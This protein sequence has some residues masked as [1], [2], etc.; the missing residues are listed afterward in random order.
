MRRMCRISQ[1][2]LLFTIWTLCL[3]VNAAMAL[4]VACVGDSHTFSGAT[5]NPDVS[6]PVQLETILKQ[7]DDDWDIE[8]FGVSGATV[9]EQGGFPYIH[10]T[11][12]TFPW[13]TAVDPNEYEL[14]LA[15]EPDVVVFQFGS[16]ATTSFQNVD[17]INEH[18]LSD[19]NAL[20]ETFAQ[21]PSKP[22]IVIC[23]PPPMFNPMYSE[24]ATLLRDQIVPLVAQLASTWNAPVVDFYAAFQDLRHLYKGDQMHVT[25][26]GAYIMAEMVASMLLGVKSYPDFNADGVV[27][28]LDMHIMVDSW[29]R[30]DP[31]CDIAP[32]PLGDGIVDIQ[33]MNAMAQYMEAVDTRL[34]MHLRLD[35]TGCD[36]ANDSATHHDG[37]LNGEPI[38][39]PA[40]GVLGG[41][42][43]FDGIDDYVAGPFV[44]NP[45]AGP[46]SFCAWIKTASP[47]S[48]IVSQANVFYDWLSIDASGKLMTP[49]SYPMPALMSDAVVTDESWHH[50]GLVSDGVGKTLYV[51]G[52]EVASDTLK[53]VLPLNGGLTL[54][55]GKVLEPDS[56]FTGLIDD[57]R[58]FNVALEPGEIAELAQ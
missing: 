48:V 15:Y 7:F 5:S 46:F 21:L 54:G 43:Q 52:V 50:I 2:Y 13:R 45:T 31:T 19:Y 39:M 12:Y 18:F 58:I 41:T 55:A 33:D 37:I 34:I 35:E 26:E 24:S 4:R 16:N 6:Y 17:L 28:T 57:V 53:P 11:D 38:W 22:R 36:I 3:P 42:L 10:Q 30:D 40:H 27:D 20:I 25:A 23:Q 29:G 14:A 44:L 49:L 9:L 56:F 47:G 8:N 51:D 32:V 1:H